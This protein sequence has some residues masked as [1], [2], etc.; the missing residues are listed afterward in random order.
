MSEPDCRWRR[1][2]AATMPAVSSAS[3]VEARRANSSSSFSP[4]DCAVVAGVWA[5]GEPSWRGRAESQQETERQHQATRHARELRPP[6]R[7]GQRAHPRRPAPGRE[8]PPGGEPPASALTRLEALLRLVDD[9]DAALAAHEAIVAMTR[10]KRLQG[11][12][13]F[14]GSPKRGSSGQ[15]PRRTI[16]RAA[17]PDS[18][19][20]IKREARRSSLRPG[21][22]GFAPAPNRS[23]RRVGRGGRPNR[24]RSPRARGEG[25]VLDQCVSPPPC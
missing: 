4:G 18:G 12:A 11:I 6:R 17:M 10:A 9:V 1:S 14:H 22:R 13:D 24:R 8:R 16:S 3:L 20:P 5:G 19:A 2:I 7:D 23:R 15:N 25:I 21:R